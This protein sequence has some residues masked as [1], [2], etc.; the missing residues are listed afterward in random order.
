MMSE[1]QSYVCPRCAGTDVFIQNSERTYRDH[2][3]SDVIFHICNDCDCK[4]SVIEEY[5]EEDD[6]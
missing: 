6:E 2:G 3:Y 4:F 5:N 1:W